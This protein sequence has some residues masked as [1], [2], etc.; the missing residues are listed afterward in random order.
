M[1]LMFV[2]NV[3]QNDNDF[4]AFGA[5][6]K[7]DRHNLCTQFMPNHGAFSLS[8]SPKFISIRP[9][10]PGDVTGGI[11]KPTA[12][13]RHLASCP[14]TMPKSDQKEALDPIVYLGAETL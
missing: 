7:G 8:L 12:V 1:L 11:K 5:V 13:T 6:E 3:A 4:L 9:A 10:S 2:R 14:V